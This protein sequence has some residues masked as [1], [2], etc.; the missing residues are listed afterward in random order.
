MKF[1]QPGVAPRRSLKERGRA[2]RKQLKQHVVADYS[3]AGAE[4]AEHTRL[5]RNSLQDLFKRDLAFP[6]S[7]SFHRAY[8][9]AP[10]PCLNVQGVGTIGLPLH[11]RDAEAIKA[12]ASQAPFGKATKTVIDKSVRDTWEIDGKDV[13]FDN[14]AWAAFMDQVVHTVCETLGVNYDASQPRCDLYKLLLYEEGSHFKAHV[15]T[16]KADG[17]FATIV[18]VLPSKFDGGAVHV[19]HGDSSKVMDYSSNSLTDTTVLAWYTDVQ[20]EVKPVTNGYRLALSFNLI[21]TTR[22]L[23]PALPAQSN[24]ADRLREV[25]TSWRDGDG[26]PAK[27]IS[28]LN[29]KYSQANLS[30][31]ALKGADAHLVSTLE[32]IARPLGFNIGL[33]NL[34]CT[35]QGYGDAMSESDEIS[36]D[37]VEETVVEIEN[38]VDLDGDL[39]QDTFEYDVMTE[40]IP[41]KFALDITSGQYDDQDDHGGYTGNE[42]ATVERFYHRTVLV[43]WPP[44]AHYDI[45]Y[46]EEGLSRACNELTSSTT[47]S[48]TSEENQLVQ[49]VLSRLEGDCSAD[50]MN[51]AMSSVSS[52]ACNWKDLALWTKSMVRGSRLSL[53]S[54]LVEGSIHTAV[55]TFGFNAVEPWIDTALK[56]DVSDVAVLTFLDRFESWITDTVASEIAKP[57]NEW[58]S[59]RRTHRL[60]NLKVLNRPDEGDCRLFIGLAL[61]HNDPDFFEKKVLPQVKS[62]CDP[63]A[64][65][66]FA[67]SLYDQT[68]IPVAARTRMARDLLELA[69]AEIDFYNVGSRAYRTPRE[70]ATSF[71]E[72]CLRSGCEGLLPKVLDRLMQSE[73]KEYG[74]QTVLPVLSLLGD[75]ARSRSVDKTFPDLAAFAKWATSSYLKVVAASPHYVASGDI[76]SFCGALEAIG[77]AGLIESQLLPQLEAL[78][79]SSHTLKALLNGCYAKSEAIGLN[80]GPMKILMAR[81]AK[82]YVTIVEFPLPNPNWRHVND[83]RH[84]VQDAFDALKCCLEAGVLDASTEV[85]KRFLAKSDGPDSG[86]LE[87]N[88]LPLLEKLSPLLKQHDVR[89]TTDAI[90][91][92]LR[93]LLFSWV[94]EVMGPRPFNANLA[95]APIGALE[96]WKCTCQHCPSIRRWL[97]QSPEGTRTFPNI[98]SSNRQH[99]E[100]F[101]KKHASGMA[102]WF[103]DNSTPQGFVVTKLQLLIKPIQWMKNQ[104]EGRKLLDAISTDAQDLR[105]ILGPEYAMVAAQ[106]GVEAVTA[107]PGLA[108][109]Q[110]TIV[111]LGQVNAVAGPSRKTTTDTT[112]KRPTDS[113]TAGGSSTHPPPKRQKR[114]GTD[115]LWRCD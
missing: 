54:S 33:A 1:E 42:G 88:V 23:R 6:G 69:V 12:R 19:S 31:S 114:V 60:D 37:E 78:Q 18:I 108:M 2:S 100:K 109:S 61:K 112:K 43:I 110:A 103:V 29:H 94:G 73:H 55:Q 115:G 50:D 82:K 41:D 32:A 63:S 68:S 53:S 21:H 111:S 16:E 104:A 71:I 75:A 87:S 102:T 36:M 65:P 49:F 35:E 81:L 11:V 48:P 91:D 80:N 83:E 84:R 47:M 58:I 22:S 89:V 3:D 44:W 24:T 30:G 101:L 86:F 52:I 97:S 39:I 28:L 38:L 62:R 46:G 51:Q 26:G 25:L 56:A 70:V 9:E 90:A 13:Q 59:A 8:P 99:I 107:I 40:I 113:E 15:D 10:N 85:L 14:R 57:I 27:I 66:K 106:L 76:V 98:G 20:H 105:A 95:L 64:L 93:S 74:V 96:K 67:E 45:V 5:I 72:T 92:P 4:V 17:M 34:I 7:S 77:Q 79:M